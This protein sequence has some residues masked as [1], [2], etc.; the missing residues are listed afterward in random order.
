MRGWG[1]VNEEHSVLSDDA[2]Y[3]HLIILKNPIDVTMSSPAEKGIV[4]GNLSGC[5]VH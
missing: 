1:D 5:S 2:P 4:T 3:R